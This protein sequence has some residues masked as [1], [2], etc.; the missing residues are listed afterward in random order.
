MDPDPTPTPTPPGDPAP[1]DPAVPP[2]PPADP[3]DEPL[4]DAGKK[5]L[6][7][8]RAKN[9]DLTKQAREGAA[10][11]ARL[12]EIEDAEKTELDR[13]REAKATLEQQNRELQRELLQS[14][15]GRAKGLPEAFIAVLQGDDEDAMSAHAD[16]LLAAMP[17]PPADPPAD[18][19][20]TPPGA[21]AAPAGGTKPPAQGLAAA[22]AARMN[23]NP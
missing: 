11:I 15:V 12:K 5:A 3:A 18:P 14:R 23:P 7:A 9:K 2:A 22:V 21:P 17:Q 10:A 8:E 4:G 1:T 20:P 6:E 16:Q 13:E 19:A